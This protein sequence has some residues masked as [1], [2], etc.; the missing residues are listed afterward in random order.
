[1]SEDI[2]LDGVKKRFGDVKAVNGIDLSVEKGTFLTLLG[3]SG[4]GKTTT[5]R[6]IAGFEEPTEGS[7]IIDGE[8]VSSTPPYDR[9][10]SMVFQNFALFPHK[11]VGENVAFGLKMRGV[12]AAHLQPERD[13]LPHGLVRE[14]REVLED[15]ARRAVVRRG[16][17]DVLPV[18]DDRPLGRFLEP[19]D[20]PKRRRLPATGGPEQR[21]KRPLFDAEIDTVHRFYV[22]EPLFDAV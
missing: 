7:V 2:K 20:H 3:P 5:L 4:C 8:D 1:M 21:E 15:H 13:V 16:R 14:E 18:D 10:T 11:S 9:P 17:R 12:D 22:P 19:R 6:M